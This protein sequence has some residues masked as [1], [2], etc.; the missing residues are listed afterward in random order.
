MPTAAVRLFNNSYTHFSRAL[1]DTGSQHTLITSACAA[2]LHLRISPV[3]MRLQTIST[4]DTVK[5]RGIVS[6]NLAHQGDQHFV[7]IKAYVIDKLIDPIPVTAFRPHWPE[8]MTLNLADPLFHQ[9]RSVALLLGSDVIPRL[10]QSGVKPPTAER[11]GALS[12]TLGWVLFGPYSPRNRVKKHV[13]FAPDTYFSKIRRSNSSHNEI[14]SKDAQVNIVPPYSRPMVSPSLFSSNSQPDPSDLSLVKTAV[15]ILPS[16]NSAVGEPS[17]STRHSISP[18]ETNDELNNL[19]RQ[20]WELDGVP[21]VIPFTPAERECESIY[22]STVSRTSSGRYMVE[23]PF[24]DKIL[25]VSINSANR[26]FVRLEHRLRR[27]PQLRLAYHDFMRDYLES[28]HMELIVNSSNRTQFEPYYIP[29]HPVHRM[30]DPPSKI[31][32]VFNAS[33]ASSNGKS[34]NDLLLTGPKLQA[35]ISTLLSRFRLHKFAFTADI[36]QMYRQILIRPEQRDFQRILWRFSEQDPIQSYRLNTVTYGVS[37]APYLALRTLQQLSIDE[38]Q[39]FPLAKQ[40]LQHEVYVDDILTGSSTAETAMEL[41]KQVQCLLMAGGFE[42]R[43]WASNHQPLLGDIPPDH[44]RD[45]SSANRLLLDRDPA[46]KVLGLGWNPEADIFFYDVKVTET[47]LT[48]RSVLSQTARIFDPL[49]WL[50]PVTFS[51]K[52]FF[53]RLCLLRLDWDQELPVE[54]IPPWMTFLA[55][56]PSLTS[57][58]IPRIIPDTSLLSVKH[59]IGFCDASESGYAA[60]VYL[61]TWSSVGTPHIS[62]V[63]ARSKIAPCKTVSLPRLELCG[64]HL[65]AKLMHHVITRV[66]PSITL[67]PTAFSDSSVAL[68]WIRGES[69][70]WKTFVGNRVAEIQTLVP[71]EYWRHVA[72]EDNPADCAS[73][74]LSP[75]AILQHPL[76]WKGPTWLL[77]DSTSWPLSSVDVPQ[78]SEVDDEAKPAKTFTLVLADQTTVID[79]FSSLLKLKRVIAFCHRFAFNTRH[80][81]ERRSGSLTSIELQEAEVSLIR[82]VQNANFSEE[83]F[84]LKKPSSRN[85]LVM[86]L[87]LFLDDKQLIRVGGRLSASL[88]PYHQ[89]HPLL[90]P[91]NSHLTSLIIDDSHLRL[92]HAGALATHSYIRRRYWI[93]DGRNVVRNRLR[94]CNKCFS[95]KPRPIIQP[96]GNLPIDRISSVAAFTTTGVDY[97]GP[98]FV[99]SARLRGAVS[100][101]AYLAVFICFATKAVH[102]EL[103]SELSTAAFIAAYRRFVARRGHPSAIFSD[104]GTNFVGANNY[105]RDLGK[106]LSSSQYQRTQCDVASSSGTDWRFI[107]PAS[108]HFGGLWEAAV[109][110]A[111]YHLT[112]VIGEQ[113]LTYEEFNTVCVQVEAILN[114]RPLYLPSSDPNDLEA[115]TPGHFLIFR[116]IV[117]PP[118]RDVTALSIN[119]L[120]RWQLVQRIHQD[121]W[122]RWRQEYLHTLQ[123]RQKWL[124]PSTPILPGTVVIIQD[125]NLPPLKWSLGRI[126]AVFPGRDGITRVAEVST[127]SGTLRRP[128]RKLCPLP[129]Q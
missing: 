41:R 62:L 50:S 53:R 80:P 57:L 11:P 114:S 81:T 121:F 48:K 83:I 126:S 42:L 117:S 54:E 56:L 31:R 32:V 122:K 118:D 107:P 73:R 77:S 127:P 82:S 124:L 38:G 91:K 13:T 49:G 21:D 26:Q 36:R 106:F 97:A 128:I 90:L 87:H 72:S 28:G 44:C 108:P 39:K 79:R 37:S 112:R 24:T 66:F 9:P 35:D 105:L 115:L 89:K 129:T 60:V 88:L 71:P 30:D 93:L 100:T 34:L 7:R 23:L 70:R 67:S 22:T 99:T 58:Q 125:D 65:L 14:L 64:A 27:A 3:S 78:H 85:R 63:A 103:A 123:Q 95:C 104:N 33:C 84:E 55:Q 1:I 76:W 25:G 92:L 101:K 4:S 19:V 10:L 20:F 45:L 52:I 86:K 110:S 69:H 109:K 68:A 47:T 43:K 113:R 120:N 46:I 16:V 116:P 51:A 75:Q 102:L 59:L 6:V 94:N 5:V 29:H 18:I 17:V 96:L 98:F 12:T 74:G 2:D 40:V 119:R 61:Q 111:K 15:T 8:L